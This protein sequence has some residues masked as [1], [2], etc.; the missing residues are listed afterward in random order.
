MLRAST[1][2]SS[3]SAYSPSVSISAASC[4]KIL[5]PAQPMTRKQELA[6]E[7]YTVSHLDESPRSRFLTLWTALESLLAPPQRSTEAQAVVDLL[8]ATVA[9]SS[10]DETTKNSM[11]RTLEWLRG[12][13]IRQSGRKLASTLLSGRLYD[14]KPPAKFFDDIYNLRNK[15]V[16]HGSKPAQI[17]DVANTTAGFIRD[18]IK[19]SIAAGPPTAPSRDDVAIT[20]YLRWKEREALAQETAFD[21]WIVAEQHVL[22]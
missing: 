18:L 20:A 6:V 8:V 16:H 11:K 21:D 10:L 15:I 1:T 5:S 17:L 13:S 2:A 4:S 3:P 7:L 22:P 12:E 19:A 14:G 9:Q